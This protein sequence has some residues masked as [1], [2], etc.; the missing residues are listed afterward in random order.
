MDGLHEGRPFLREDVA[1]YERNAD[2]E[3]HKNEQNEG[4][5]DRDCD[6]VIDIV[7]FRVRLPALGV[8]RCRR[9]RWGRR[10]WGR[11]RGWKR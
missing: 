10:R 7:I 3:H 8:E 9:R 1:V 11:R 2:A 6:E 4:H 5:R